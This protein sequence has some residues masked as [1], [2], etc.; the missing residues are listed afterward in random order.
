MKKLLLFALLALTSPVFAQSLWNDVPES[1]IPLVGERRI[2]PAVY[3]SVWLNLDILQPLLA[4]AP[5]RFT[6]AAENAL[7]LPVLSLPTP[8]GRMSRFR[9]TE[10]PVM[11]P[12]L[13]AK[14]PESRCYTGYGL[15]DPTAFLKCDLTPW[16]FHAMVISRENGTYSIDPY[17]HG[18]RTNYVVYYK[19]DYPLP[20]GKTFVCEVGETKAIEAAAPLQTPDQGSCTLKFY[21]LA[22]ACT[23]EYASFQGGTKILALAAMVT[24]VNRVNGVYESEVAVTMGII[25]NDDLLIY[26]DANTDPYTNNNGGTML[27]QNQTTC[28]N[29]IGSANYDIGHVFST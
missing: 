11:A 5:E 27:T 14:Y 2:V 13:Q 15:D 1:S 3:R 20:A 24:S 16:G 12:E 7:S 18:D 28:T 21:R 4:S 6:P 17:S 26:L 8:D 23:G 19:K 25:A 29:V 22:L 10:S 9:L